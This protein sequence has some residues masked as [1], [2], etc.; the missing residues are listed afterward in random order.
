MKD[1]DVLVIVFEN[2]EYLE[3]EFGTMDNEFNFICED[4]KRSYYKGYE[5]LLTKDLTLYISSKYNREINDKD[6]LYDD[7]NSDYKKI[8]DRL[9]SFND[10][11]SIEFTDEKKG[12]RVEIVPV[13]PETTAD[14]CDNQYQNTNV[15]KNGNLVIKIKY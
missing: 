5:Q 14:L 13:W 2:G 4:I 15:D 12:E 1:K 6:G 11:V 7:G 9:T 10:I 8:F 3:I